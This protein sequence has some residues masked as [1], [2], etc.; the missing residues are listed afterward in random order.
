MTVHVPLYRLCGKVNDGEL[1]TSCPIQDSNMLKGPYFRCLPFSIPY[2]R[3]DG[4]IDEDFYRYFETG[5]H[6]NANVAHIELRL[7]MI[8]RWNESDTRELLQKAGYWEFIENI[9]KDLQKNL[10]NKE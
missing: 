6:Q 1:C 10:S 3:S 5:K 2:L 7:D 9:K 4:H 8:E